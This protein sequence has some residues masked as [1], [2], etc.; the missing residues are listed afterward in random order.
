MK[1]LLLAAGLVLVAAG[2]NQQDSQRLARVGK[3]IVEQAEQ[4]TGGTQEKLVGGLRNVQDGTGLAAKVANRLR[5]DT[6]L[7]D[8][9]IAV[10]ADGNVV[11]LRGS[12]ANL[13]QRR[14]AIE[15]AETTVGVGRVI[16]LLVDPE[17]KKE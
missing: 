11:E 16:D 6:A 3:K 15:L 10:R 8:A 12:A 14:R 13:Q 17:T 7:A 5:W 4:M 9:D 2:C 1:T